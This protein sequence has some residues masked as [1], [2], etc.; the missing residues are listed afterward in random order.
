MFESTV[1]SNAT[2]KC[3][4][5]TIRQLIINTR[6]K[7]VYADL[8][9]PICYHRKKLLTSTFTQIIFNWQTRCIN[10]R[11]SH[12]S[13][14]IIHRP[15]GP[16]SSAKTTASLI[17][18]LRKSIITQLRLEQCLLLFSSRHKNLAR[19]RAHYEISDLPNYHFHKRQTMGE[20]N[21]PP[22]NIIHRELAAH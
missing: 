14:P 19:A 4:N 5:L 6:G 16:F 8:Y 20:K 1:Y 15:N 21:C 2:D 11:E 9:V 10:I 7:Q 22:N 18:A 17:T 3:S 12:C 13:R